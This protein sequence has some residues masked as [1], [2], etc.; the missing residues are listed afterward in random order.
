M[1]PLLPALSRLAICAFAVCLASLTAATAQDIKVSGTI[2]GTIDGVPGEWSTLAMD[3][4]GSTASYGSF[5]PGF[6]TYT[7]QGHIGKTPVLD[8][9][10]AITFT[11]LDNGTLTEPSVLYLHEG[12]MT[13]FYESAEGAVQITFDSF[14]EAEDVKTISGSATGTV[15]PVRARGLE[16]D[17]DPAN[18]LPIE[19]RFDTKVYPDG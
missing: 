10:V 1:R 4:M 15:R 9:A 12:N 11:R 19:L 2:T 6:T 17:D 18:A 3:G 14:V 8:R 7:I 5:M 16:T 13:K